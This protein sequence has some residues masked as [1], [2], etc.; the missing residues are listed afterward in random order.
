MSKLR[1][2]TRLNITAIA[3]KLKVSYLSRLAE[4]A[5]ARFKGLWFLLGM[6]G[7]AVSQIVV[8]GVQLNIF[9]ALQESPKTAVQLG[10]AMNCD[11]H[12]LFVQDLRGTT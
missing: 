7:M 6:L 12:G 8:T 9:D 5:I 2:R 10:K 4:G 11:L 1:L 3:L